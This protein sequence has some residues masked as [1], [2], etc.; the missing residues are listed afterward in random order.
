MARATLQATFCALAAAQPVRCRLVFSGWAATGAAVSDVRDLTARDA[1]LA[2]AGIGMDGMG[3]LGEEAVP[4]LL[5]AARALRDQAA[6]VAGSLLA[7][8]PDPLWVIVVPCGMPWGTE[9]RT[10]LS[11]AFAREGLGRAVVVDE[12]AAAAYRV[13][14]GR[15]PM[16]PAFRSTAFGACYPGFVQVGCSDEAGERFVRSWA[17]VLWDDLAEVLAERV[18]GLAQFAGD[19]PDDPAACERARAALASSFARALV[20]PEDDYAALVEDDAVEVPYASAG[21][22]EVAVRWRREDALG[23]VLPELASPPFFAVDRVARSLSLRALHDT[24]GVRRIVLYGP[25]ASASAYAG[26]V[27]RRFPEAEVTLGH[28]LTVEDLLT[29]CVFA[30]P[31]LRGVIDPDGCAA[32]RRTCDPWGL[33]ADA[34]VPSASAATGPGERGSS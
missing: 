15:P 7:Q 30:L 19:A 18:P 1:T 6:T 20:L 9:R 3:S 12:L 23:M 8:V 25:C 2:L 4:R 17:H 5:R 31:D 11:Q 16:G 22:A 29:G 28:A 14:G 32:N 27:A 26:A 10:E 34:R 13:Y 21:G 24:L 33:F